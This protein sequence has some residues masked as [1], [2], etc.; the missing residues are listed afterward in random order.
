MTPSVD[1]L[2]AVFDQLAEAAAWDALIAAAPNPD[3]DPRR[4]S[5]PMTLEAMKADRSFAH[6][7]V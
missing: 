1:S 2:V 5:E 6:V 7:A 3:I 4:N